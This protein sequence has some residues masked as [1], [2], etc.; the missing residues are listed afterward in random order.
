MRPVRPLVLVHF[1]A[2]LDTGDE[3]LGSKLSHGTALGRAGAGGCIDFAKSTHIGIRG[4]SA[5]PELQAHSDEQGYRTITMDEFDKIGPYSSGLA[6]IMKEGE[7]GFINTK[8][9]LPIPIQYECS[10][11]EAAGRAGGADDG[12]VAERPLKIPSSTSAW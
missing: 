4:I 10:A 5:G 9:G 11:S 2:H 6:L 3:Y 7:C 1:D 8:G 12:P